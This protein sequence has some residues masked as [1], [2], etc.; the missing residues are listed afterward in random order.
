M[1]RQ[2]DKGTAEGGVMPQPAVRCLEREQLLRQWT[3]YS[4]RVTKLADAQ[5]AA[6]KAKPSSSAGFEARIRVARA[7]EVEASCKYFGHVKTHECV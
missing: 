6:T 5:L 2:N 1:E 3:D 4:T 7:G